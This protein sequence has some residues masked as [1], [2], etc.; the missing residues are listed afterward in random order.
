MDSL[1]GAPIGVSLVVPAWNEEPRLPQTLGRYL[2]ALE[3]SGLPF[4]VIVVSD[5]STDRTA[6]VA[7]AYSDRHVRVLPFPT[8]L[9]KGGAV[10][11]GF[12]ASLYRYVGFVDADGPVAP[13]DLLS[14]VA[15]LDQSDCSIGSRTRV[16]R[17]TRTFSRRLFSRGWNIAVRA[18]LLLP[19]SDTQCGAKFFRREVLLA[20]LP[21][22]K[23]TNWA[24]DISLLFQLH[25]FGAT[26]RE[27]QVDW[28]ESPGSKLAIL[29]DVPPMIYALAS[30]RIA[31]PSPGRRPAGVP[32]RWIG[33]GRSPE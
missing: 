26:I 29:K 33:T 17:S 15:A 2:P 12:R 30:V 9:G 1:P 10:A 32:Y 22:V 24:F 31:S 23:I 11:L 4:E 8:R 28:H 20:V 18:I 25:H 14:L 16:A 7:G 6:E 13:Y 19:S 21:R 5:G 27:V 3:S